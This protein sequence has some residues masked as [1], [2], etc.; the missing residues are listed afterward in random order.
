MDAALQAVA[1]LKVGDP[2]VPV[3]GTAKALTD[4]SESAPQTE[5]ILVAALDAM[6]MVPAADFRTVVMPADHAERLA[7][8]L[9]R[10]DLQM[11]ARLV[12]AD[13]LLREGDTGESGRMAQQVN[14]WASEHGDSYLLARSH[15]LLSVFFHHV[16][17]VAD[18]L[19]HS[20]ECVAHTGAEVPT[21]IR[22]RHLSTLAISL[23]QNGSS[24]EARRRF[25]EALD[26]ATAT[27]D[28][29][30][31]LQVLNN[32][33]YTAYEHANGE[34]AATLIDEMRTFE[35]RYGVPLR[36]H[37]LDTIARIEILRG[38]YAE[39]EATLQPIL[40]G[41][42]EH[43]LTEGNALAE[44][45]RTVAEAQRLR[46]NLTGAQTTLDRAA[47]VCEERGLASFR[48]R[49]REAQAQLY[50]ATDRYREAYEEHRLFHTEMQALQSAQREARTRALQVAFETEEARRESVRFREMAQRD[51]LTGLYNRRFVDERLALLLD[52]AAGPR[53]PLSV[54]LVDLD[55]FKRINDTLS[56]AT[57][58]VVLQQV[59]ALLAESV[60]GPAVAA[61]LGGEEF[62]L[63]LPDADLGEAV[64]R[65]EQLRQAIAVH[66]WTSVTGDIP[67]T[68]SIGVTTVADGHSTP[69]ALL[70]QADRNL[71]AAKRSGRNRVIADPA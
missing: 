56:H 24:D 37:Y 15:H 30:L 25:Q 41:S 6:E 59:A 69:S 31:S 44:C 22:A 29:E 52:R 4:L 35:T 23:H 62:L 17:D 1:A 63:I 13:V 70:A 67:V 45:L 10:V 39:A 14:A 2:A 18:A 32:M 8:E 3:V 20:V 26:I 9:G 21:R 38:R 28:Y 60:T 7:A 71:Y 19:G 47:A 33:A 65:C 55:H 53:G 11:R 61:R 51:S 16:G 57:G 34:D 42:A 58:D 50:A 66:T 68:A 46:G 36:A 27:G 49:V 12:R 40:D 48:A 43:L 5:A 64:R 54:A